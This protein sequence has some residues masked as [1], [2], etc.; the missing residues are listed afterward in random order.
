MGTVIVLGIVLAAG[1]VIASGVWVA[2]V[3]VR[4]VTRHESPPVVAEDRAAGP[5]E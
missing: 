2:I 1:L 5:T 4:A 3:L